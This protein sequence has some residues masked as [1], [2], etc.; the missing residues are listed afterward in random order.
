MNV[1]VAQESNGSGV[2]MI[3]FTN[4]TTGQ[5]YSTTVNYASSRSSAEWIEE[6]PA[7]VG[8]AISLDNFGAVTF[9]DGSTIESG[10]TMTIVGSGAQPL[11]MTNQ[12]DQ[13]IAVPSVL[14]SDGMSF[15][16]T[17]TVATSSAI[18]IGNSFGARTFITSMPIP[19]GDT[20]SGAPRIAI[21]YGTRGRRHQYRSYSYSTTAGNE[22]MRIVILGNSFEL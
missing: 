19:S 22:T 4:V 11:T 16:V 18:G 12:M 8:T 6:M 21:S 10:T 17:R 14:G 5:S 1:S 3:S 9:T 2:W 15:S 13:P 20:S 7:G